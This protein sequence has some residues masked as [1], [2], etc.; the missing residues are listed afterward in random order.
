[1]Y[2]VS[3]RAEEMRFSVD[4]RGC[5]SAEVQACEGRVWHGCQRGHRVNLSEKIKSRP[6]LNI[7]AVGRSGKGP[8]FE[9][10]LQ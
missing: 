3:L 9:R 1:M 2:L 4:A 10:H 8:N 6:N 5:S 7:L